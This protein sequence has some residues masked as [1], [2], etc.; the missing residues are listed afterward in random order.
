MAD[1]AS[2]QNRVIVTEGTHHTARTNGKTDICFDPATNK[3]RAF[4]N[5][6]RSNKLKKYK[7]VRTKINKKSIM[8]KPTQ[9]GPPSNYPHP[10]FVLSL[11][12]GAQPYR[13]YAQATSWSPDVKAE[14]EWVVRSDDTTW[15][16][17]GPNGLPNTHGTMVGKFLRGELM[18]VAEFQN[19]KCHL[20]E[21][22]G[23]EVQEG[24]ALGKR[25][26]KATRHDYL[27]I[28]AGQKVKFVSE[29]RDMTH[30]SEP[31]PID[32][33]C[34]LV[35]NHTTWTAKRSGIFKWDKEITGEGKKFTVG[36]SLTNITSFSVRKAKPKEGDK[37]YKKPDERYLLSEEKGVTK[38][39]NKKVSKTEALDKPSDVVNVTWKQIGKFLKYYWDPCF[40]TVNAMACN[41]TLAATLRMFP[42]EELKCTITIGVET[43]DKTTISDR[44]KNEVADKIYNNLIKL[45]KFCNLVDRVLGCADVEL[46]FVLFKGFQL[47]FGMKYKEC[48]KT[49]TTRAGDWRSTNHV[50]L[51]RWVKLQAAT[52]IKF[53][54]SVTI[55]LIRLAA[56]YITGGAA[57]VVMRFL[58]KFEEKSGLKLELKFWA[59]INVGLALEVGM[60]QHEEQKECTGTCTIEPEL[61]L[62]LS[63]SITNGEIKLSSTLNG[64]VELTMKPPP[65]GYFIN[66]GSSGELTGK[67]TIEG[68]YEG[69]VL[70]IGPRYSVSGE[71]EF[72][73]FKWALW[74][75]E[76]PLIQLKRKTTS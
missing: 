60:D 28:L 33:V 35:P 47:E 17:I 29:R 68:R 7:T 64:K 48:T 26:A 69:R 49:L 45:K 19:L 18:T 2:N 27:E 73:L 54:A 56:M 63:L 36:S 30:V 55:S 65:P 57:G 46:E 39:G 8:V 53:T 16:N 6:I 31:I 37:N 52:L 21:L 3:D 61:G 70:Y 72:E 20:T 41:N 12:N 22:T 74:E 51:D 11:C 9:I 44:N 38:R 43:N 62:E 34:E 58:N 71:R 15:Q 14:G 5:S 4:T 75:G 59:S 42:K 24:R 40:I 23:E 76:K 25:S 13:G 10:P 67:F 50:G 66:L 1:N 32:P